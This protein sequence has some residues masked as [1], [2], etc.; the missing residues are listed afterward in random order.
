MIHKTVYPKT[1]RISEEMVAITEKLDGSNIGFF[2]LNGELLVCT[3]NNIITLS[4]IDTAKEVLYKGLYG[5]LVEQGEKLKNS[6]NETS[7][8]FGEWMGTGKLKYN[9]DKKVYIFAKAN[10]D[11]EFNVYN[12]YYKPDLLKYPF[13][14]QSI[15]EFLDL[16]P[17]VELLSYIPSIQELNTLY[18]TYCNIVGRNVEGFVLNF[19]GTIRKY[20]RMK[21]GKLADHTY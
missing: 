17:Y 12:I 21:N 6:L 4:E 18:A 1:A 5:W 7:G 8:F 11:E 9:L 3:R 16:V 13:V 19:G 14:N 2:K 10:L 20:V 15:P